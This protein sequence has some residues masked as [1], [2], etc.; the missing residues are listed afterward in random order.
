MSIVSPDVRK[1]F[2]EAIRRS[3]EM[4]VFA[5]IEEALAFFQAEAGPCAKAEGISDEKMVEIMKEVRKA[6]FEALGLRLN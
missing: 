3:M 5:D 4:G 1:Q 6:T 2:I